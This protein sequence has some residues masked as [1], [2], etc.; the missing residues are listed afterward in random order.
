[1]TIH[2]I[3][4]PLVSSLLDHASTCLLSTSRPPPQKT[5]HSSF[6]LAKTS[7]LLT[8][9]KSSLSSPFSKTLL[10]PLQSSVQV[11]L[12][13][14]LHK[15]L[16]SHHASVEQVLSRVNSERNFTFHWLGRR[17]QRRLRQS[18]S[19]QRTL[20][21]PSVCNRTGDLAPSRFTTFQNK[22]LLEFAMYC[23][24]SFV[25]TFFLSNVVK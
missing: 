15:S 10:V 2:S 16:A 14:Q 17:R 11:L 5:L 23:L 20:P 21:P 18:C 6:L 7:L 1:M 24:D 3:L 13:S 8:S 12:T 4:H 19:R 22:S 25:V 9:T